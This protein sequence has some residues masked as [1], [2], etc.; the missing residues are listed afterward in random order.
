MELRCAAK[1]H[2]ELIIPGRGVLE[3]SCDSRFCGK[4]AGVTVRHQF[5][6]ESG[7]MLNTHQYKTPMK[8]DSDGSL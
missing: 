3:V 8:G 5:D 6:L 2:G 4:R 7:E 1:K